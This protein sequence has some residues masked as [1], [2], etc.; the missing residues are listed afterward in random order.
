MK[1]I[2]LLLFFITS[3]LYSQRQG[4]SINSNNN[5]NRA[6]LNDISRQAINSNWQLVKDEY[7]NEAQY[8]NAYRQTYTLINSERDYG[9]N[10]VHYY[11]FM[12]NSGLSKI[13]NHTKIIG[14]KSISKLNRYSKRSNTPKKSQ[15]KFNVKTP[16]GLAKTFAYIPPGSDNNGGYMEIYASMF[17]TA[18]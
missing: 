18:K 10:E 8:R 6:T 15:T 3:N 1:K 2:F 4:V 12:G 17:Y 14:S 9:V 7:I 5:F 13:L 11:T 16:Y